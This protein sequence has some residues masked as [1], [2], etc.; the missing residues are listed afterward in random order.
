MRLN[1]QEILQT[2]GVILDVAILS[3][4]W[5]FGLHLF[6]PLHDISIGWYARDIW[7]WAKIGCQIIAGWFVREKYCLLGFTDLKFNL[8][9]D[10][11]RTKIYV[12]LLKWRIV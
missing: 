3:F 8:A 5:I 4:L 6:I 10:L 12:V 9:F 1:L 2:H 7:W 11:L